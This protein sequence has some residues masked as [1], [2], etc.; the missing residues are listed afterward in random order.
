MTNLTEPEPCP[1]CKGDGW[2]LIFN[3][4]NNA[5]EIQRC[6]GCCRYPSDE[7]ARS[8]LATDQ[9]T[10]ITVLFQLCSA[11][12]REVDKAVDKTSTTKHEMK[13]LM[14][15]I[16]DSLENAIDLRTTT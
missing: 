7:K 16:H 3:T 13:R 9:A 5:F 6:D 11:L 8:V 2:L 12:L 15:L 14:E 1:A 4:D 10:L